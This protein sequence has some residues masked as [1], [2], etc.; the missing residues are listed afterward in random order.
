MPRT[1]RVDAAV[2]E[3]VDVGLGADAAAGL[4]R[5]VDG[6]GDGQDRGP[7]DRSARAGGV[8]VD[9]VQPAGARRP[10][11]GAARATGSP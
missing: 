8:E 6:G 5:D 1:T 3:L 10:R 11:T 7:V 4:D 9:H 2:E